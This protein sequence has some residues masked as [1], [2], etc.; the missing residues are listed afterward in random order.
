MEPTGH[1]ALGGHGRPPHT[2]AHLYSLEYRSRSSSSIAWILLWSRWSSFRVSGRSDRKRG[3]TEWNVGG[4]AMC[5]LVL[6]RGAGREALSVPPVW[7][8]GC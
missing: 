2:A 1:T 3:C 4:E 6:W 8:G 7:G 5:E